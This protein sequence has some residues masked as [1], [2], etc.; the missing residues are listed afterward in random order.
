MEYSKRW[1]VQFELSLMGEWATATTQGSIGIRALSRHGHSST[2][3]SAHMFWSNA[4]TPL[5]STIF[6]G[7]MA[8]FTSFFIRTVY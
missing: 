7:S 3:Q 4:R 1:E 5:S 6:T 2:C 8:K